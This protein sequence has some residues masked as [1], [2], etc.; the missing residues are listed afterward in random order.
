[1]HKCDQ[2][3]SQAK[4]SVA[5]QEEYA[6]LVRETL[7]EEGEIEGWGESQPQEGESLYSG[8]YQDSIESKSGYPC[9]VCGETGVIHR[10]YGGLSCA[11][12][13]AFFRRAVTS[14]KKKSKRCKG[15]ERK[16]DINS[17][18]RACAPCRFSR[19]LANGMKESLVLSG[20]KE[21][22]KHVGRANE[23][24]LNRLMQLVEEDRKK[25]KGDRKA[26]V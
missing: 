11:P 17:R 7:G 24:T 22:L 26:H 3:A 5:I 12:C 20:K 1:M 23:N 14:K 6:V 19:C 15:G 13:K 10:H 25:R 8:L 2:R 16:C 21:A 4:G 9:P 18:R